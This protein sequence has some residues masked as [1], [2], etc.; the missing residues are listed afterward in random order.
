MHTNLLWTIA[1]IGL[2]LTATLAG[3]AQ[4]AGHAELW[5]AGVDPDGRLKRFPGAPPSD[6]MSM[7]DPKARWTHVAASTRAFLLP[8]GLVMGGNDET[9]SRIFSDLSRRNIP[10]AVAFGWLHGE[11]KGCGQ[12]VEG[13]AYPGTALAMAKKI[14]RLGGDLQFVALDEPL[15]FGHTYKGASACHFPLDEAARRVADGAAAVKTVFPNVRIGD[16]EPVGLADPSYP[17][18]V[19]S[20][21]QAYRAAAGSP[22]AFVHADIQWKGPWQDQLGRVTQVVRNAGI[23][24]GII[25]DGGP[26]N[27]DKDWTNTAAQRFQAIEANPATRPDH[28]I[29]QTWEEHPTHLLPEDEPGTLTNLALRYLEKK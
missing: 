5:V 6:L 21:L 8:P 25:Y 15:F 4:P 22:L 20:W 13:F 27:T 10:L 2:S 11:D 17:D 19:R 23:P 9:L 18:L 12:R 24:F 28:A 14:Q 16:I 29:I 3:R 26:S 7:F 1:L